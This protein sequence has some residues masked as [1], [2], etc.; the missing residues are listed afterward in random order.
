MTGAPPDAPPPS[1]TLERLPED[2]WDSATAG[3]A[4]TEGAPR[5]SP[6]VEPADA[7]PVPERAAIGER[8]PQR[9]SGAETG[10]EAGVEAGVAVLQRLF[11]GRVLGVEPHAGD[12]A[13]VGDTI[14]GGD[15]AAAVATGDDAPDEAPAE[16]GLESD[17]SRR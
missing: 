2:F 1:D 10:A 14:D 8:P 7:E 9:S 11:P 6:I 5:S 15:A 3:D 4:A 16:G 13:G 12:E 17:R